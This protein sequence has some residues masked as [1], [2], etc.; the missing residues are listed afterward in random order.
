MEICVPLRDAGGMHSGA[1]RA[2]VACALILSLLWTLTGSERATRAGPGIQHGLRYAVSRDRSL[3]SRAAGHIKHVIYIVKENRTYD[4]YFGRYPRG[5]GAATGTTSDGATIPLRPAADVF[6]PDLGHGFIEGV[7]AIDGGRMDGFDLVDNGETLNGYT[8]FTRAG[9]PAYWAYAD[10]FVLGD[11]MF[12]SMY[13]PSLPEH[14]FT[15]AAR[16]GR[17]VDNKLVKG[18]PGRDYCADKAERV[19][20]FRSLTARDRR[21]V[22][23]AEESVDEPAMQSYWETAR[24][25]FNFHTLPDELNARGISWRYYDVNNS[26]FNAV[27]AIKHLFN[28]EYWGPNVVPQARLRAD[29][30]RHRLRRVSW[31]IPPRGYNEHPG[32]PSVCKGENWTVSLMNTLMRSRYWRNTAVFLTWDDFGGFYDHVVPPHVDVMGFGPRVPL[33]VISPWAKRGYID[34][35][36]YEFSSVVTFIERLFGIHSLSPRDARAHSMMNAFD[37]SHRPNFDA[38]KVILQPRKCAGLPPKMKELYRRRASQAFGRLG[39]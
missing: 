39:D 30:R 28:S 31:V 2:G 20:R 19:R 3:V 36:T 25:C 11:R 27:E 7:R 24:P 26:W 22:M 13:G 38:R 1:G 17:V 12:S 8:S 18:R 5:D 21:F 16:A 29:I 4:H 34:H 35:T 6:R 15:I 33:L 9:L 14:L 32:G 10:N 23:R 37:F